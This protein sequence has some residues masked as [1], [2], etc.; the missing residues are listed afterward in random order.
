MIS[1]VGVPLYG[2]LRYRNTVRY[3]TRDHHVILRG[4]TRC[5]DTVNCDSVVSNVETL[6]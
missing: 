5:I 3:H 2:I 6:Q 4:V 1:R